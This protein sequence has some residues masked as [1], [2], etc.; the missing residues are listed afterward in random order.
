MT[1]RR[2]YTPL[3][4]TSTATALDWRQE[5]ACREEDPE[6]FYPVGSTGAALVQ[7]DEAKAVCR[8]CPV[9]GSCRSYALDTREPHGVWGGLTEAERRRILR[10]RARNANASAD[11]EPARPGRKPAPCG[12]DSAY[13][14]HVRN[15]EPIDDD[16]RTAHKRATA[17]Y[18]SAG[19]RASA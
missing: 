10:R 15:G 14:R 1:Y 4:P 17:Q 18:R 16:C 2:T 13:Q 9:W 6:L 19:S 8:R 12:T 7:A 3:G 11:P 5:G